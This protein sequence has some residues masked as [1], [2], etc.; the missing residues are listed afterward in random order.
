MSN[1]RKNDVLVEEISA[2]GSEALNTLRDMINK[3]NVRQVTFKTA[4][5][6]EIVTIPL[7]AAAVGGAIAV[8][9]GGWWVW[10]VAA[11]AYV[12]DMKIE[13]TKTVEEE[14]EDAVDTV[15]R[16]AKSRVEVE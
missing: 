11:V 10:I 5:G 9:F 4:A 15:K 16:K 8:I 6:R 13:V 14:V 12:A 7:S 2:K 1:K 3:G